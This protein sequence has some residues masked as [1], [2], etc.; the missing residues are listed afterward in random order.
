MKYKILSV[1]AKNVKKYRQEKGWTQEK[2][3]QKAGLHRTYIG[4]IER[5]ER[6]V[7][8]TNVS[9]FAKALNVSIEELLK[10]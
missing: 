8:L 5:S 1:F 6:N 10:P 2:L 7:S 9:K 3:A 4:S